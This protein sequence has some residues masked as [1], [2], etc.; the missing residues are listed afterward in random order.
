ME[1]VCYI[2]AKIDYYFYFQER[3]LYQNYALG[4]ALSLP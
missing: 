4:I 1:C 2:L 3:I